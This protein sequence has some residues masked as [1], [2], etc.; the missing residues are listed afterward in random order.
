MSCISL[1]ILHMRAYLADTYHTIRQQTNGFANCS[2]YE[3]VLLRYSVIYKL[4]TMHRFAPS[5]S[6]V[7]VRGGA[8]H[9][10]SHCSASKAELRL[11]CANN[12]ILATIS[13]MISCSVKRIFHMRCVY[14]T[15]YIQNF[16]LYN[17]ISCN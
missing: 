2:S 10:K 16:L 14:A 11:W 6:G 3:N 15:R 13:G 4:N 8:W 9:Y 1:N 5:R 7:K 17:F 12:G